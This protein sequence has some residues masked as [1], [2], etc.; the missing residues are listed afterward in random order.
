MPFEF[1]AMDLFSP[2]D[3]K[4]EVRKRS[5]LEELYRF[6]DQLNKAELEEEVTKYGIEWYLKIQSAY[7]PHLAQLSVF[8]YSEFQTFL[9]MAA[10]LANKRPIDARTQSR[11]DCMDYINPNSLLL[12]RAGPKGHLED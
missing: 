11:E 8:T 1:T 10:N 6:L 3:V 5:A 4:D 7:S 9:Y 12:G 2:Y